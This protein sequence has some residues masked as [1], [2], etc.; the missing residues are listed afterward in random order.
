MKA[1]RAAFDRF[2]WLVVEC[3]LELRCEFAECEEAE[4]LFG[5]AWCE[6]ECPEDLELPLEWCDPELW[7]GPLE[8]WPPEWL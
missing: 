8:R 1:S 6:P 7:R 4:G 5:A 3:V 2:V